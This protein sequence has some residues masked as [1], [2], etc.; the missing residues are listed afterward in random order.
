VLLSGNIGLRQAVVERALGAPYRSA[1]KRFARTLFELFDVL[2][3]RLFNKLNQ[4]C[5]L[6][7]P[8][9]T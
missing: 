8:I 4:P 9:K 2:A 3:P 5:F 7:P 1:G 6:S